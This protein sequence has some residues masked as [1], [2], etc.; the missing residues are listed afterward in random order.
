M[1]EIKLIDIVDFVNGELTGNKDAI[2]QNV[3]K[4]EEAVGGDLS[5]VSNPK[6]IG[7]IEST[8][9]TALFV[10]DDLD[11]ESREDLNII[12]VSDPYFAICVI[13]DHF[14]NPNNHPK[15][16]SKLSSIGTDST[17]G[18]DCYIGDFVSIGNN[19]KI[20]SNVKVYPNCFIGDEVE[21]LDNTILYSNVS[22]YSKCKIG[23]DSILHSGVVVGSDG[24]G[25]APMPDGSY[26]KIP[27]IGNVLIG[28]Y[29]EIGANTTI[30][31]ATMGSTVI[32]DG[33]KLDNLIQVAHNARIGKNT[34]VAS[35]TGISGSTELGERCIIG[36]QVGFVG[37]IKVANG[38]KIGAQSGIMKTIKEEDLSFLGSPIKP[39]KDEIKSQ[40]LI[41]K[42]PEIYKDVLELKKL[43]DKE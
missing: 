34:V 10:K 43:K 14:F 30:D 33:V 27:Q 31:R 26:V 9:A 41:R 20:G 17:V 42:L 28:N 12:R 25:H 35:Q 11:F 6:Y 3:A 21:V 4:I 37:H 1:R 39:L 16:T 13:M 18:E 32:E 5:F 7:Y 24:F 19:V 8:K 29:V 40:V 38:T 2:I 23:T 22:I 15:G 36:G